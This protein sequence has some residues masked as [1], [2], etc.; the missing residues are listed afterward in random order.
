VTSTIQ[1]AF[2]RAQ[3]THAAAYIVVHAPQDQAPTIPVLSLP[4]LTVCFPIGCRIIVASSHPQHANTY[5]VVMQHTA[6]FVTFAPED[7]FQESIRILPKSLILAPPLATPSLPLCQGEARTQDRIA[8]LDGTEEDQTRTQGQRE[9][10][11]VA[12]DSLPKATSFPV[13]H[14]YV[15]FTCIFRYLGSLINYSLRN[16]VINKLLNKLLQILL[17]TIWIDKG[18]FDCRV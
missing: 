10:D 3:R 13:S 2:R 4:P 5:G 11:N 14:G 18:L 8:L 15:S 17:C 6:K 16:D 9:Q 7:C 1:L 12:Y